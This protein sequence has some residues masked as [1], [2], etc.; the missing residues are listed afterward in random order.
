MNDGP[1]SATPPAATTGW[2]ALPLALTIF[3]GL[4]TLVAFAGELWWVLDLLA[5]FR[6]QYLVVLVL[7]VGLALALRQRRTGLLAAALALVDLAALA[8]SCPGAASEAPVAL[9]ILSAN[10]NAANDDHERLLEVIA[11]RAP[12]V[13]VVLEVSPAWARVLEER[14][15]DYPHRE[16]RARGDNF[17]IALLS[18]VPLRA[19]LETIG[20]SGWPPSIV[21]TLGD[22]TTLIATH[23]PPPSSAEG[24]ARRD[25][26]LAAIAERVRGRD[27]PVI[28]V[29]DLNTTP[30]APSFAAL[31]EAGLSDTRVGLLV[32]PTWPTS[33]LPLGVPIDHCLA[34][35]W[36]G[37]R[38]ETLADIGSD[39]YPILVALARR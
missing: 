15:V 6:V 29:G 13:V 19:A 26:Q 28:V 14:L 12:D 27:A 35:G 37:V 2:R 7:L 8:P 39:H 16:V 24:A 11:A 4:A 30:W 17:G 36:R 21:A 32:A 22:G 5:H 3:V 1:P 33:F 10:V 38:H 25:V 23:P 18:R 9:S 34:I 31:T 20:P